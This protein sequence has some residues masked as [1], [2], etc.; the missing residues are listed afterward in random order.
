MLEAARTTSYR[1]S[2]P[3]SS[4]RRVRAVA[5]GLVIAVVLTGCSAESRRGGS[6]SA[7]D[8]TSSPA[9]P[10]ATPAP[11]TAA[12]APSSRL[13]LTCSELLPETIVA[14]TVAPGLAAVE[15]TA[16]PGY[17]IPAAYSIG[18]RG[19]TACAASNGVV[20]EPGG[21]APGYRGVTLLILPDAVGQWERYATMYASALSTVTATYGEAGGVH[22]FGRGNDSSCTANILVHGAWIDLEIQGIEAAS[23]VDDR[24]V[25]ARVQPLL[26]AVVGRV[27][28][29]PA[30]GP[31]WQP[32]ADTAA[33]PADC[34]YATA[35]EVA[36]ALSVSGVSIGGDGGSGGGWSLL[37][38]ATEDAGV[39]RCLWFLEDET[40]FVGYMAA[41]HGGAWAFDRAADL[42][43]P[44]GALQIVEE[45][46]VG[47]DRATFGCAV[48]LGC[49]LNAVIGGNWV[50]LNAEPS[51]ESHDDEL[52]AKLI[53]LAG[54]VAGRING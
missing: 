46:I 26:E 18:Q 24:G 53:G 42:L 39:D 43:V 51:P 17:A 7:T 5:V 35:A 3:R 15:F 41:L 36:D 4:V 9:P 54:H 32:P 44:A 19:G 34:S 29:A 28:R 31:L 49:S 6:A 12:S 37:A 14:R 25:A 27:S 2:S 13:G 40:T 10:S 20:P 45:P 21:T 11:P 16:N 50:R 8:S 22:C 48:H 52:K 33:L 1:R 30:A 47:V 23:D 38:A